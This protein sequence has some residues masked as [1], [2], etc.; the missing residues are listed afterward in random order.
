MVSAARD[1][2]RLWGSKMVKLWQ[3]LA[4]ADKSLALPPNSP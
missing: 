2:I 3:R 1:R 4:K